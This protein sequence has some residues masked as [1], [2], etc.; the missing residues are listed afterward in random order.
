MGS[1]LNAFLP[2]RVGARLARRRSDSLDQRE[3][4]A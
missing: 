1:L 3:G 4:D 2:S